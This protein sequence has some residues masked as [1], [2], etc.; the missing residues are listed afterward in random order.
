VKQ[1]I[2]VTIGGQELSLI[3][4]NAEEEEQLTR[5]ADQTNER[6]SL[7][8]GENSKLSVI[9]AFA[10]TCLE[11]MDELNTANKTA[12]HLREEISKDLEE[13]NR[14]R[15]ELAALRRGIKKSEET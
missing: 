9:K 14:M 5:L 3:A 4:G 6:L 13:N 11:L 2:K 1:T 10:L 15:T 7:Y 8:L 12:E